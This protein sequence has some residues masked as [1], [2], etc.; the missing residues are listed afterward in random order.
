M[1]ATLIQPG[2]RSQKGKMSLQPNCFSHATSSTSIT[3]L[4]GEGYFLICYS[5]EG[6][7]CELDPLLI[8]RLTKIYI[9]LSFSFVY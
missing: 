5:E 2:N 6:Q 9:P 3:L 8:T 1:I 4:W 7:Q